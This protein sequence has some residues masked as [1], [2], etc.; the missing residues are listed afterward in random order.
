MFEN[1]AKFRQSLTESEDYLLQASL[2][3]LQA[4]Q[5]IA[6]EF[7]EASRNIWHTH[8]SHQNPAS[9]QENKASSICISSAAAG[10]GALVGGYVGTWAAVAGA[11]AGTALAI[12][13]TTRPSCNKSATMDKKIPETTQ[14]INVASFCGIVENVCEGIDGVL[15][16]Y[17]VQV[18]RIVN[19]YEQREKPSL[20]NTYSL[21]TD[22]IANVIKL[23]KEE[24]GDALSKLKSAISI[25]EE[26][27][28]NYD[29]KYDNGKI[30][31][32]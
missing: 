3:L 20:Q 12:Y 6:I 10:V 21:L 32:I 19:T 14:P 11:I 13:Y 9:T 7:A 1:D 18:K 31:T 30:V 16:T 25:L 24:K 28:E 22:Q 5:N 23:A 29:L 17:R 2:R 4:Q 26:S 27:L 8:E 15:D